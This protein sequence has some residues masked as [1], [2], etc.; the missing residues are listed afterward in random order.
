MSAE[1][2]IQLAMAYTSSLS[3]IDLPELSSDTYS[4]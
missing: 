1:E 3:E 4:T 2:L